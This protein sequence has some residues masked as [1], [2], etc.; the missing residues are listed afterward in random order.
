M[1]LLYCFLATSVA[2]KD[3]NGI[4]NIFVN[5]HIF[6]LCIILSSHFVPGIQKCHMKYLCMGFLFCFIFH[7]LHCLLS[8][9]FSLKTNIFQ[10]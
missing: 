5:E 9:P 7:S 1:V 10:F 4:G 2:S 3:F 8:H 6:A